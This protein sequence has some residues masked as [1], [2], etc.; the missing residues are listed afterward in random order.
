MKLWCVERIS[1]CVTKR[2]SGVLFTLK[3]A[4]QTRLYIFA[5]WLLYVLDLL[6]IFWIFM[7]NHLHFT[8]NYNIYETL[9]GRREK[10]AFPFLQAGFPSMY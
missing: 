1:V 6:P 5:G 3:A 9:R 2:S 8:M 4:M 10:H 7:H